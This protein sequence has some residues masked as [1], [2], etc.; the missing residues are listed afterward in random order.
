MPHDPSLRS[1]L[2]APVIYENEVIGVLAVFT[3]QIHRFNNDEKRL[4]AALASLGAVAL[5]N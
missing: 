5:Q 3:D 1:L 2:A 4:L